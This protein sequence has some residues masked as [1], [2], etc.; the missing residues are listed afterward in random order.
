MNK[1]NKEVLKLTASK[2]MFNMSEEEY[3]DLV[4]EFDKLE[5]R[6]E[7]IGEIEGVDNAEPMTFPFDVTSTC[8]RDDIPTKDCSKEELLKNSK[9]VVDGQIRLPKVIK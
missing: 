8:L 6:M 3:D 9:D 5:N 4:D 7:L 1:I 2:L